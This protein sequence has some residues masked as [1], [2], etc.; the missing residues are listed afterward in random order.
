[1]TLFLTS[2]SNSKTGCF[3]I[4]I[5]LLKFKFYLM[6]TIIQQMA[7]P[8]LPITPKAP[9]ISTEKRELSE[10]KEQFCRPK[11]WDSWG[12]RRALWS[13][14]ENNFSFLPFHG[15]VLQ[16]LEPSIQRFYTSASIKY[17]CPVAAYKR[18]CLFIFWHRKPAGKDISL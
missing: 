3:K 8:F 11:Q 18:I 2:I 12:T 16:N 5:Y 6:T 9:K 15:I 4:E 10:Q 1:M 7:S 17:R 13:S 14:F